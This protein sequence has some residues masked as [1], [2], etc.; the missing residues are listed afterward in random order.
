MAAAAILKRRLIIL[1]FHSLIKNIIAILSLCCDFPVFHEFPDIPLNT[2]PL[3]A[4]AAIEE[5]K[6]DFSVSDSNGNYP[7]NIRFRV[8][9]F[10]S[11]DTP[12]DKLFDI[13]I[14]DVAGCIMRSNLN[15][16]SL[17]VVRS[18]INKNLNLMESYT[19]FTVQGT[20]SPEEMIDCD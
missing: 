3:F 15:L 6:A 4:V 12:A 13:C 7:F 19:V 17:S 10:A 8:S 18:A 20:A 16:K 5:T 9:L 11:P 14:K 2:Y 1:D